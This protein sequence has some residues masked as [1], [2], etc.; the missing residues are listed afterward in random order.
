MVTYIDMDMD[1][2]M[3]LDMDM[4]TDMGIEDMK[5]KQTVGTH[6]SQAQVRI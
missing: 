1:M 3:D 2:D 6:A 4:G 5:P